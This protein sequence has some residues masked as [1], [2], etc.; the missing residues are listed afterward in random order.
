MWVFSLSWY[1]RSQGCEIISLI[2]L[3]DP[4]LWFG[5]FANNPRI[6][7]LTYLEAL[8]DFGNFGSEFK[9]AKKISSFF[10]A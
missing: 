3:S 10:G 4:I 7:D 6:N 2:P 8:G 5:F 9:I 1:P